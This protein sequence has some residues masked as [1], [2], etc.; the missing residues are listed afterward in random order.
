MKK[1]ISPSIEVIIT[2]GIMQG[3]GLAQ[4]SGDGY[5]GGGSGD[6]GIWESPG[7][8]EDE[9]EWVFTVDDNKDNGNRF[10]LKKVLD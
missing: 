10:R 9:N 1:Y 3:N 6:P 5:I 4:N 2:K 8:D 7:L